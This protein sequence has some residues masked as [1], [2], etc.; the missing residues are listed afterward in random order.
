VRPGTSVAIESTGDTE[1]P[2]GRVVTRCF[3]DCEE[4][5]D[6]GPYRLR[7]MGSDGETIGTKSVSIRRPVTFHVVDGSDARATTATTL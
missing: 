1:G 5:L 6:P 3:E 7:L 2:S 4:I